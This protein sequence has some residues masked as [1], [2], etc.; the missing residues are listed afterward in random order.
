MRFMFRFL[1]RNCLHSGMGRVYPDI[2]ARHWRAID[3]LNIFGLLLSIGGL[4]YI[5]SLLVF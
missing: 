3:R 5:S 4:I 1:D 2:L